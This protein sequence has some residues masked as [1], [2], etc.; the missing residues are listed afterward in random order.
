MYDTE[1]NKNN[2][3]IRDNFFNCLQPQQHIHLKR[4]E[5]RIIVY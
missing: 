2:T 3:C 5:A 1:G 4:K